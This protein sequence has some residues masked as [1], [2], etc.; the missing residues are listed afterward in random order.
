MPE[1]C[2]FLDESAANERTADRKYGWGTIGSRVRLKEP[3]KRSERYS[4][5]PAYNLGG[6]MDYIVVKGSITGAIFNDFVENRVLPRCSPFPGLN[7][8]LILDNAAIHKSEVSGL[9]PIFEST[10]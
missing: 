10:C 2:V 1:Q 5:L 8:I 7:S 6:Y 3:I 9:K 4:I